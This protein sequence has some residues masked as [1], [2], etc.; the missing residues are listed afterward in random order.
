MA[1]CILTDS[2]LTDM[3]VVTAPHSKNNQ[4]GRIM[5]AF[6]LAGGPLPNVNDETL[7]RYYKYLAANMAFPFTVHYPTPTK[8]QEEAQFSCAVLELLDPSEYLG[9]TFDGIF[10]KT[11]KGEYEINLPLIELKVALGSPN[12]EL[13]DD[14]WYWF[15]NWR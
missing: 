1:T 7:S 12:F 4:I 2:Q 15:W 9:D 11:E 8:L 13:I 14:F 3:N 10:C 6:G 5:A